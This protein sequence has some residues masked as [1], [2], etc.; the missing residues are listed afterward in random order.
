[1]TEEVIS[2]AEKARRSIRLAFVNFETALAVATQVANTLKGVRTELYLKFEDSDSNSIRRLEE[3]ITKGV[4][5]YWSPDIREDAFTIDGILYI[6]KKNKIVNLGVRYRFSKAGFF[7]ILKGKI[8]KGQEL[9]D[10]SS[11]DAL[12]VLEKEG[13]SRYP[14]FIGKKILPPNISSGDTVEIAFLSIIADRTFAGAPPPMSVFLEGLAIRLVKKSLNDLP[15]EWIKSRDA[16][17]ILLIGISPPKGNVREDEWKRV[18]KK[19]IFSNLKKELIYTD[20]DDERYIN[21][22]LDNKNRF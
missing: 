13:G 9:T 5:I 10:S 19:K 20:L 11:F 6:I 2:F 16:I 4:K 14:I 1:L 12:L 17:D 21:K 22:M 3:L 15:L 8:V 18:S 7:R